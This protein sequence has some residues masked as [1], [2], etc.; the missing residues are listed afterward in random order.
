V[1]GVYYTGTNASDAAYTVK[2]KNLGR[3][4]IVLSASRSF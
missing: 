1:L 4:R 2:G 3:D